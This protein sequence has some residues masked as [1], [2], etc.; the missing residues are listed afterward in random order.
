MRS[1]ILPGTY[2]EWKANA[3]GRAAKTVREYLEKNYNEADV[4]ASESN[5]IKLAIKVRY[6]DRIR[7]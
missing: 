2:S 6:M 4:N 5:T 3:I 1:L 7:G